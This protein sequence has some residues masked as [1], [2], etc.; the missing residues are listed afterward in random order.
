M[1]DPLECSSTS[2][3]SSAASGVFLTGM[4]TLVAGAAC[5]GPARTSV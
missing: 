3:A 4:L 2:A 1:T 5:A